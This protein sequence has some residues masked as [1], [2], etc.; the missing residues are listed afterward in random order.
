MEEDTFRHKGLRKKLVEE[1]KRKGIENESVLEALGKVPRHLFMDTGFVTFAYKDQAFPIGAGQTISQPYTVAFQTELLDVH[2]HQKVLEIG[3]GSGYQAAILMEM[4]ARVFTIER[5]R[6]LYL[7]AQSLIPSMGYQAHFFYGDGYLGVHSFAPY[8]RILITAAAPE[9]PET[10]L[11]Q[12]KPGGKMVVPLGGSGNQKMMLI[13][14]LPN[15]E[16]K[17]S[18]HGFFVFVPMLKGTR[19]GK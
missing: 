19:N 14:K 18:Q 1:V 13:E 10:L 5:H 2:P 17:K 4:G 8:D 16:Y 6:P 15:G 12:L 11:D 3:T 7:K 9:I